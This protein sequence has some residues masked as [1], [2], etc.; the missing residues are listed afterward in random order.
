MPDDLYTHDILAW[1]E[2]QAAL[3]RRVAGG[4]RVNE[5]DWAHV[6]EEVEDVGLSELR[7]VESCVD[8]VLVHLLKV[9][10]WPNSPSV[11]HWRVEIASFQK[12]A[13]RRF[14]PSMRQRIDLARLYADALEQLDDVNYDDVAPLPWPDLCPFTLEQLLNDNRRSLEQRLNE[15]VPSP[16]G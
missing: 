3:L 13:A 5:V 1:S 2:H 6:V 16:T 11:R 15:S 14:A 7:A 10:G 8:R 12:N 9:Q 4:E